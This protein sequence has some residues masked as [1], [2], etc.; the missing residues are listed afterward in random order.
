MSMPATPTLPAGWAEETESGETFFRNEMTNE[1]VGQRNLFVFV[2]LSL[3][4]AFAFVYEL[5]FSIFSLHWFYSFF[6]RV[7]FSV[8]LIDFQHVLCLW[9]LCCTWYLIDWIMQCF[10]CYPY[11][12]LPYNT[13]LST[14]ICVKLGYIYG[15]TICAKWFV[16]HYFQIPNACDLLFI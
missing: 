4:L 10:D 12:I 9:I 14:L 16:L 15:D 8:V 3:S 7:S 13:A 1:R 11:L 5:K 2:V 6:S